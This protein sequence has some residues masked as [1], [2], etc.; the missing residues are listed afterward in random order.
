M[1]DW[2]SIARRQGKVIKATRAGVL[3]KLEYWI[4]HNADFDGF[5]GNE[6]RMVRRAIARMDALKTVSS[7]KS[8]R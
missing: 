1:K 3:D 8:F 2:K 5:D 7:K 4:G 6:G